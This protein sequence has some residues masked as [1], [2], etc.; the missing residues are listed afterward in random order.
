MSFYI[1]LPSNVSP[2][3]YPENRLSNYTVKLPKRIIFEPNEYEVGLVEI[4]YLRSFKFKLPLGL[5]VESPANTDPIAIFSEQGAKYL[6]DNYVYSSF[7][8]L[9]AQFNKLIKPVIG[10]V[11]WNSRTGRFE[12]EVKHGH[13]TMRKN[14]A[15]LLGFDIY[16]DQKNLLAGRFYDAYFGVGQHIA[17]NQPKIGGDIYQMYVYSD[18]VQSQI[19]GDSLVPLLRIINLE[20]KK[21]EVVNQRFRPYY[22][23]VGKLD[24]DTI[25]IQLCDEFGE[26]LLF[27]KGECI[28]TLHFRKIST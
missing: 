9:A 8:E 6:P 22:K 7:S 27:K 21:E 20:G 23:T 12:V 24:F 25:T 17:K 19:V 15:E 26:E 28:I 2:K 16:G 5:T 1:Y 13:I 10:F 18:I 3:Y 4:S 11:T 14:L